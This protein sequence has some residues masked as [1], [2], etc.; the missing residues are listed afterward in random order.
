MAVID[1]SKTKKP[2][3]VDRDTNSFVGIDLP[4]HRSSGPE[5]NFACTDT[6]R[7]AVIINI[8][9][10]LQTELK[11]RVFQPTL[12][13]KLRQFLF[14]PYTDEVKATIQDS[15]IRTFEYWLPFVTIKTVET[16][17]AQY[18]N[19]EGKNTLKVNVVFALKNTPTVL[20]SVTVQYGA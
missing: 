20:E 14:E 11:E 6:V 4:L 15:I 12:G 16:D 2:Y 3:V 13:V 8:K 10:L 9:N 5:G 18:D 1:T 7:D 19:D 17:M